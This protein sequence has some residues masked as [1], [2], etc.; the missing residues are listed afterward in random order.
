MV[1]STREELMAI[2]ALWAKGTRNPNGLRPFLDDFFSTPKGDPLVEWK[3]V[4]DAFI[5]LVEELKPDLLILDQFAMWF[6][7]AARIMNMEYVLSAPASLQMLQ[8]PSPLEDPLIWSNLSYPLSFWSKILN[9]WY[10]FGLIWFSLFHPVPA[11]IR[12]YRLKTLKMPSIGFTNDRNAFVYDHPSWKYHRAI[13][14]YNLNLMQQ[15]CNPKVVFVGACL[16]QPREADHTGDV[17]VRKWLDASHQSET[18]VIYI[19]LGTIFCY[20]Q[21]EIDAITDSI[22]SLISLMPG[23]RKVSFLWRI[24]KGQIPHLDLKRLESI[25][26]KRLMVVNWLDDPLVVFRHPAVQVCVNHGGGNSVNEAMHHGLPQLVCGSWLDT[27]DFAVAVRTSG[28]GL[29]TQDPGKMDSNDITAK[30]TRLLTEETFRET[31][32]LYSAK[33]R[34]AGGTRAAVDVI[35][36]ILESRLR[37][38]G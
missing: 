8:E 6:V 23:G 1:G 13:L 38:S 14:T 9:L 37:T 34:A 24:P 12:E 3:N 28:I 17:D 22:L 18:S 16:R 30:I 27:V 11:S 32:A 21:S 19:N 4:T 7:D 15:K 20:L 31:A 26:P 36:S 35:E 5:S 29:S 10:F 25:P 33:S 2:K